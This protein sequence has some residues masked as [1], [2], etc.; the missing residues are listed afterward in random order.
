MMRRSSI[1][2]VLFWLLGGVCC[3]ITH[4]LSAQT[5]FSES[6]SS[7]GLDLDKT[8]DGGLAFADFDLDG[9]LDVLINTDHS[10][11]RSRLYR[12]D[13]GSFTD[14]TS[15]LAPDLLNSTLERQALWADF[16]ND[17]YPDFL[18]T[19]SSPNPEV[20]LQDPSTG[21][22]GNG[23]GGTSSISLS[24]SNGR[25]IEGTAALDLEGDGDLD[26]LFENHSH[27]IDVFRNNYINHST[28]TV[29]DPSSSSLFS[30][31]TTGT[32]TV[33]GFPQ[34]TGVGDYSASADI[35]DDGWTDFV[36]RKYNSDDVYYN[37]GGTF[38]NSQN[39]DQANNSRKGGVGLYDLDNDA[40]F[41]LIWTYGDETNIWR[42]D[43]GTFVKLSGNLSIQS[44]T[45]INGVAGGDV[46]NDGDIDLFFTGDSKSYLFINDLNDASGV[47]TGTAFQF[48]LDGTFNSDG[49]NSSN[50][51]GAVMVDIDEDGDL[52]IFENKDNS[53]NHLWINEL[54]DGSTT[55]SAKEF[56]TI[57]I[58]ENRSSRMQTG[59]KR[60]AI[61]ANVILKDC[62]G[63]TVSG[64]MSVNGG[65]GHGTQDPLAVHIGLPL[66]NDQT[67]Q[68]EV[69]FPNDLIGSGST[70]REIITTSF[71]P[72]EEGS[73]RLS[74]YADGS[75]TQ[76]CSAYQ[77]LTTDTD[78]DGVV[79]AEDRD[80]DNDGIPDIQEFYIGDH[81]GDGTLDFEDAEYCSATFTSLGWD[82]N[83]GL[84]DPSAD[85]AGNDTLNYADP[86]FPGCGD[87]LNAVCRNTDQDGDGI[88][89]HLDLDSDN[90]GIFDLVE[91]GGTASDDSGQI[92]CT[93]S[94]ETFSVS[95]TVT[96]DDGNQSTHSG[97]VTV[98]ASFSASF[99]PAG[100]TDE[101]IGGGSSSSSEPVCETEAEPDKDDWIVR[102]EWSDDDNGSKVKNNS[103]A[104]RLEHRAWGK[105]DVSIIRDDET[106]E[107]ESGD[108]VTITF[109]LKTYST[110]TDVKVGLADE[111]DLIWSGPSSYTAALTSVPNTLSSSS[112]VSQTVTLT[113]NSSVD[114]CMLVIQFISSR[115]G[116][117][118]KSYL[119]NLEICVGEPAEQPCDVS[120]DGLINYAR[121]NGI[122]GYPISNLTS[123]ADYPDNPDV[124]ATYST[125]EAPTDVAD[126][127]GVKMYGWI[128]PPETGDY[129]FW[130]AT[131]DYGE[132]WLSTN[133]DAANKVRIAEIIGW[134]TDYE[135]TKY[136]SQQSALITLQAGECYYIEALMNE[137]G[138]LDNVAVGWQLPDGTLNRPISGTY[139]SSVLPTSA[140]PGAPTS[141]IS[142]TS[143]SGSGP[144]TVNFSGASSTDEGSI[145]SYSW[146]FGDGNSD[147]G[148]T[149]SNDYELSDI[150]D[151]DG[152][153][154]CDVVDDR[155]ES[156]TNGTNLIVPDTDSDDLANF[157]ERDSDGDNCFDTMETEVSDDN[158][159]GIAGSGTLSIDSMGR[160]SGVT[161]ITPST[162]DW[163][164]ALIHSACPS[165]NYI[166]INPHVGSRISP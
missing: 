92:D 154:W 156:V 13:N 40:D 10:S 99:D 96:D 75:N 146:N 82:C 81:D 122:S 1:Y 132:L 66:G 16:N 20:Y 115:D 118:Q 105:E 103:S 86:S 76:S 112:Y 50:G 166:R 30:Q 19:S 68:I 48:D 60:Y 3:L 125:F 37:Q 26:I 54:Y 15:S 7:Y 8:K 117:K 4:H 14:V 123:D 67:Y 165:C 100:T 140:C 73:F 49:D 47:G 59:A 11:R 87:T 104:L 29:V 145:V 78:E 90:D 21:K 152:D 22:F 5:T 162:N 77:E 97:T 149:T 62:N 74:V 71:N 65:T 150:G 153:G 85:L 151:A 57:D 39:I 158:S 119:K 88:P 143:N 159:D 46:D 80:D 25:N 31:I 147:T 43:G 142:V 42:N 94:E 109:D 93:A 128:C 9:D 116:Y 64:I 106:F 111:D 45:D 6:A 161:Y 35:D 63:T 36:A 120:A 84:P 69:H 144:Y 32:G 101:I 130:L 114:D 33:L 58:W 53:D 126:N 135:W 98:G 141:I 55:S 102:N 107:V 23:T 91:A 121:F 34:S 163:L 155:W 95:L 113:A 124:T 148:V 157:L 2:S 52:D 89:N 24:L 72:A 61:G 44:R 12:N 160:V 41:D 110:M 129:T 133:E 108:E 134:T 137:G 56:L 51:Q 138:G 70:T 18:R 131:D 164:N 28:G 38:G 139:L 127:Y 136:S 27:G 79:D 17:R 83:D